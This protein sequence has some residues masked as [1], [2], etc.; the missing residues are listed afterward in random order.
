MAN[1]DYKNKCVEILKSH[2]VA[3]IPIPSKITEFNNHTTLFDAFQTLLNEKVLSAPVKNSETGEYVGF[4][5]I[6]DLVAFVVF[7]Y[8]EQK[9][10]NDTRLTDIVQHGSG[11]LRSPG[12][13]GV[14]ITYLARR[15]RFSPVPQT[16][17][18]YQVA[19]LLSIN[20]C[21]RVPVVEDGKV[22]NVISQSSLINLIS[23]QLG[24]QIGSHDPTVGSLN[25]GTNPV[26]SANQNE[27]VINT[28][29]QMENNKRSGIA[30]VDGT[31]KLVGTTTGKDI[32]LF[33][34]SPHL[35]ILHR[36]IFQHLQIVRSEMNDIRTPCIAVFENDPL[37]RAVGLLA[38]TR[39]HRVYV[40]TSEEDYRPK[41]V[42]SI[43]DI[44]RYLTKN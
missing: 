5:D 6:R 8:D 42:I 29:R 30:L 26:L 11:M 9:V 24:P 16:H 35:S 43:S 18:L 33:L 15:H 40:V 25:I 39:V 4:L 17:S 41:A 1:V 27:T 36:T 14:T 23:K 12:T 32:G 13:D 3:S 34:K 2:T 20:E 31:G 19:Q 44:L 7:I 38:A 22:V 28:F 37:S 21:H 10:Q